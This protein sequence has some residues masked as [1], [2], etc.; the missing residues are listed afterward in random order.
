M[1]EAFFEFDIDGDGTITTKVSLQNYFFTNK[2][3]LV[4]INCLA[5]INNNRSLG[6]WWCGLDICQQRRSWKGWLLRLGLFFFVLRIWCSSGMN[7]YLF[8]YLFRWTKTKM[9]QLSWTN[10]CTWWLTGQ[11]WNIDFRNQNKRHCARSFMFW[12]FFSGRMKANEKIKD[13]FKV[14]DKDADGWTNWSQIHRCCN[15]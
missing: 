4:N 5:I 10:F 14:F 9:E 7:W 11:K 8:I 13:V 15:V 1:R 12:Y 3:L 6:R 2:C